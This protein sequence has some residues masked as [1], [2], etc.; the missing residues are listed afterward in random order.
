MRCISCKRR[1]PLS[2]FQKCHPERQKSNGAHWHCDECSPPE[3]HTQDIIDATTRQH[4]T[5][6]FQAILAGNLKRGKT[7]YILTRVSEEQCGLQ[8]E[9]E[10][11]PK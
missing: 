1:K 10:L 6:V 7:R 8:I 5:R 11:L 2:E 3:N 9:T 4:N